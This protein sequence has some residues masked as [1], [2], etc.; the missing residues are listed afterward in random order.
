M[1]PEGDSPITRSARV[2]MSW[3]EPVDGMPTTGPSLAD[4][5]TKEIREAVAAEREACAK[6]C[7]ERA[8][9]AKKRNS[10]YEAE[11]LEDAAELI[12]ARGAS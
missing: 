11:G 4:L 10:P 8:E 5:I 7:Y 1:T 12:E 3:R 9:V 2:I 6:L